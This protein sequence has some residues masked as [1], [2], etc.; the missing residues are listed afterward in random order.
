MFTEKILQAQKEYG[1][2]GGDRFKFK[3]G[4]NRIRILAGGEPIATH[5]LNNRGYTCFGKNKGCPFHGDGAIKDKTGKEIKPSVKF[6]MYL[7]DKKNIDN[8][9]QLA[10]IP[11]SVIKQIEALQGNEDYGFNSLPMPYDLAIK[12]NP[13]ASPADMYSTIPSPKREDIA[14]EI[15]EELENKKSI[16]EIVEQIKKNA[17]DSANIITDEQSDDESESESESEP[18]IDSGT[19]FP[20]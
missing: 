20:G 13:S 5:F 7:L 4:D 3:D 9:I 6:V 10:F 12:Y 15:L 17:R 14:P 2:G 8:S 11:Y 18:E 16:K 19:V 1:I